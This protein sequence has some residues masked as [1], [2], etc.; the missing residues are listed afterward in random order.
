MSI[1]KDQTQ[2]TISLEAGD[3]LSDQTLLEI[4]WRDPKGVKGIFTPAVA[5]GTKV[6]FTLSAGSQNK[7]SGPWK[8]QIYGEDAGGKPLWGE[9]YE[10]KFE[11]HIEIL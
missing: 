7:Y 4:H 3:D 10:E 1:F 8:F 11:E 2:L 9:I 6:E 5:V